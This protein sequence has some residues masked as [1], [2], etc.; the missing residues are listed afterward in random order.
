MRLDGTAT[1]P[2]GG[3]PLEPLID[4]HVGDAGVT[5]G[6]D[7]CRLQLP[8]PNRPVDDLRIDVHACRGSSRTFNHCMTRLLLLLLSLGRESF[9]HGAGEEA[10]GARLDRHGS[11]PVR[12]RERTLSGPQSNT[13]PLPA[14]TGSRPS[15]KSASVIREYDDMMPSTPSGMAYS[16]RINR[17]LARDEFNSSQRC[18]SAAGCCSSAAEAAAAGLTASPVREA[19]AVKDPNVWLVKPITARLARDVQPGGPR[20]QPRGRRDAIYPHEGR[21]RPGNGQAGCSGSERPYR[22]AVSPPGCITKRRSAPMSA[23]TTGVL[24]ED[25]PGIQT[26]SMSMSCRQGLPT[27]VT[28]A[29][30]AGGAV[31]PSDRPDRR[32]L[33]AGD[34]ARQP[35]AGST[36]PRKS[37]A[38]VRIVVRNIIHT[39]RHDCTFSR[40]A[41]GSA[42]R[43]L[44][45]EGQ[46]ALRERKH[47]ARDRGSEVRKFC[48]CPPR[49]RAK[50]PH[51]WYFDF[52]PRGG[53]RVRFS[54]DVEYER[55]IEGK[56]E[57]DALAE[58]I[59]Q[60][61]LDG[62]FVRA[63][64]RRQAAPDLR[65]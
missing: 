5:A 54:L 28:R 60:K 59:R 13:S 23:G 2:R 55:H 3:F 65:S 52:T 63:A 4:P 46:K 10:A 49:R 15:S 51:A 33:C 19:V 40:R 7:A 12:A 9:N 56:T 32:R 38:R 62:T 48:T 22:A 47:H 29:Q 25:G 31:R 11:R 41:E 58:D 14:S 6:A 45:P 20:G 16:E 44:T 24:R 53:E 39:A 36:W 34:H 64:D 35:T 57:A 43:R 61:I 21:Y 37:L 50:C 30:A 27:T 42:R 17:W 26:T 1:R 18:I 8:V